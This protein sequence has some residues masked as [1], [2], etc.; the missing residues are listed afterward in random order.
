MVE[1]VTWYLK[2]VESLIEEIDAV[3]FAEK[4]AYAGDA[5]G[6]W[7]VNDGVVGRLEFL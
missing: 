1:C 5:A 4:V 7:S 6:L 3:A 2:D